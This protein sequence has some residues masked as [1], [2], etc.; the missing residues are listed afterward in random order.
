[1]FLQLP[2]SSVPSDLSP[3]LKPIIQHHPPNTK[4]LV[5]KGD[6]FCPSLK[7]RTSVDSK[8]SM[9]CILNFQAEMACEVLFFL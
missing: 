3:A 1:M 8:V 9:K 4:P 5:Y 2:G 6:P 7:S